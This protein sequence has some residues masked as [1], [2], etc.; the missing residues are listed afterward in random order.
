MVV[1]RGLNS[2]DHVPFGHA[3]TVTVARSDD[4]GALRG[5]ARD[6][7][8]RQDGPWESNVLVPFAS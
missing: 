6:A 1:E 5:P 8:C 4:K 2:L 7:A 3:R